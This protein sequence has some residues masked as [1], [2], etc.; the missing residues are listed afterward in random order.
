M[1]SKAGLS[2]PTRRSSASMRAATSR[3]LIPAKAFGI[4]HLAASESLAP[5]SAKTCQLP[6]VLHDSQ[7]LDQALRAFEAAAGRH[8][9]QPCLEFAE[10]FDREMGRLEAGAAALNTAQRLG[11]RLIERNRRRRDDKLD[12]GE[13]RDHALRDAEVPAVGDQR[14]CDRA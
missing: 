5:A 12:A 13:V 3:S 1:V 9:R 7:S 4:I 10:A 6:L 11:K 14:E 2:N 8:F